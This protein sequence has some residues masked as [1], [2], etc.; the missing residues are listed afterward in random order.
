MYKETSIRQIG[1]S[2]RTMFPKEMLDRMHL[3]KGDRVYI[4][5]TANGLL[6]TPYDPEFAQAMEDYQEGAAKYRNALRELAK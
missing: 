3:D 6:I 2:L 1:N 5:E 4:A